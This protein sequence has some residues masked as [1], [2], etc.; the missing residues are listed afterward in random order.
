MMTKSECEAISEDIM[1]ETALENRR[2]QREGRA[3]VLR[4]EWIN[5]NLT[6][7]QKDFCA[8]EKEAFEKFCDEG[9]RQECEDLI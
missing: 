3:E 5:Y 7:L 8:E 9:F 1:L 4:D 6:E 2:E